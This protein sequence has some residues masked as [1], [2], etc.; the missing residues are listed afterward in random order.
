MPDEQANN[1]FFCYEPS[2]RKLV[3]SIAEE[4]YNIALALGEDTHGILH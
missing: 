2:T 3:S 4:R 1:T